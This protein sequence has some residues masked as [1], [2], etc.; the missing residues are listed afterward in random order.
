VA[1]PGAAPQ[2]GRDPP[3]L[4]RHEPP[5]A[6]QV[7]ASGRLPTTQRCPCCRTWTNSSNV[8]I[9]NVFV[10]TFA[11]ERHRQSSYGS[12]WPTG[13]AQRKRDR[14]GRLHQQSSRHSHTIKP[15]ASRTRPRRARATYRK[16]ARS[17]ARFTNPSYAARS[18]VAT[19]S[20]ELPPRSTKDVSRVCQL[21]PPPN[22]PEDSR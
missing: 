10:S 4:Y 12:R 9:V 17:A 21:V 22:S 19:L 14:P 3:S 2:R 20:N 18:A 11:M 13:K 5:T 8:M 1:S 7:T 15:R 6:G 16:P